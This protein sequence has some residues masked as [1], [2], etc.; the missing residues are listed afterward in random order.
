MAIPIRRGLSRGSRR[1]GR[2]AAWSRA[3]TE[4][5]RFHL[6]R[7]HQWLYPGTKQ[8]TI[9]T[10]HLTNYLTPEELHPYVHGRGAS[11]AYPRGQPRTAS[12]K[13]L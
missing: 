12:V 6:A 10:R 8:E 11:A 2:N 4:Y 1:E 3:Y 5:W 9:H 7:E 13:R